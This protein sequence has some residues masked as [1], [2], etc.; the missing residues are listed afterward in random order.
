MAARRQIIRDFHAGQYL[1]VFLVSGITAVLVIRLFLHITGYP[2]IG[3]ERLHIAHMLWG[4]LLMLVSIVLLLSFLG[5][6]IHQLAALIGGVGFGAFIDEVGKF[7]TQDNDYFYQPAVALIYVTF[8]LTY[9]AVR[10]LHRDRHARPEEYLANA[11][12]ELENVAV[13]DLDQDERDRALRYLNRSDASEPLVAELTALLHRMPL[14]P[15]RNPHPLVRLTR[16][17]TALYRRLVAKPEFSTALITFFVAQL[18]LKIVHLMALIVQDEGRSVFGSDPAPIE[19]LVERLTFVDWAQ[20]ASSLLS[21]VFVALGIVALRESR[22]R[23]LRMFQRS[24]LASI[25]L[26]QVFMFYR[27]QWSAL[28]VL[29]FNLLLLATLNF[30]I[31]HEPARR[32]VGVR[33]A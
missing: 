18:L 25:F 23:A 21:A 16:A 5:R 26:T 10:S 4:G 33:E 9:L 8:I 2:Q 20:L 28:T 12:Q 31:E 14:V 13:N 29:G 3:G 19:Q 11:L 30:M 32:G 22:F 24:I 27:D 6:R 15:T 1:D 7:V 17:A